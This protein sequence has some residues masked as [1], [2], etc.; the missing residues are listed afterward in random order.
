MPEP[1]PLTE[2]TIAAYL[3][4]ELGPKERVEFERVLASH[5][6]WRNIVAEQAEVI[7]ALRPIRVK[8]PRG[9]VWDGYWEQID[10]RLQRRA[11]QALLYSGVAMIAFGAMIA[12][13]VETHNMVIRGGEVLFFLGIIVLVAKVVGG[14]MRET[15]KHRYRNIRR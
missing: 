10:S 1:L 11:G 5:P 8:A 14:R 12:T 15:P 3:D 6:E 7:A 2:E 13:V 4:G 9:K